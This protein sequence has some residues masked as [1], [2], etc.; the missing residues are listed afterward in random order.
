VKFVILGAGGQ[1][2]HDLLRRLG[3]EDVLPLT[4]EDLDISNPE[5]VRKVI[6]DA[7]PDVVINTAAF[8]QVDACED[9]PERAFLVN[10][11]GV[12]NVAEAC[13]EVDSVLVH[14][15]TDYVFDGSRRKPWNESDL[16]NP[17][18][19]YGASKVAGEYFARNISPRHFVVRSSGL[20][21]V[22]GASGKGG[23]FVETMLRVA[24]EGKPL[25]VVD[26][27]V[28]SPTYTKDL[29]AKILE[30]IGSDRYG[31]FHISNSG[32]CSWYAFARAIFE[33]AGVDADLKPTISEEYPQ[34]ARRPP[35]SVLD[36]DAL[37]NLGLALLRPWREALGDYLVEKGH[38]P[39]E[40]RA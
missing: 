16:P 39:K 35:Y 32:E 22:K 4:H 34:K 30:L 27:Q 36:N 12:R 25:R 6:A 37:R 28:L 38:L 33:L 1:L 8:H 17:L 7:E 2:A 13:T 5:G 18:S 21:G 11:L 10:A 19:V 26:D 9:E 29:A 3:G 24:R 31:L 20:Y 14:L 23:N 15:S 40:R